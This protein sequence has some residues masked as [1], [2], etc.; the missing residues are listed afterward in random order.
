MILS[1]HGEVKIEGNTIEVLSDLSVVIHCLH[2]DI[3]IKE[4]GASEDESREMILH[5]VESGFIP[6]EELHKQNETVGDVLGDILEKAIGLL[7]TLR[8]GGH[9][10]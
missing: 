5:A 9:K 10:E 8:G 4:M 1:N 3:F 7:E 2:D 6:P